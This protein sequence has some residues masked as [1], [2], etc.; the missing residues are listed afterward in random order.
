MIMKDFQKAIN[1]RYED[2]TVKNV[3]TLGVQRQFA[4]STKEPEIIHQIVTLEPEVKVWTKYDGKHNDTYVELMFNSSESDALQMYFHA[5]ETY[6]EESL[7]DDIHTMVI[8]YLSVIPFEYNGEYF[9]EAR[10]PRFWWDVPDVIGGDRS[11]L[12]IC[13]EGENVA[14]FKS[15]VGQEYLHTVLSMAIEEK[16]NNEES[17][18]EEGNMYEYEEENE[19]E[20]EDRVMALDAED[21]NRFYADIRVTGYD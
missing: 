18:E 19:Q 13:F 4:N 14:V 1:G 12:R 20:F 7:N 10:F 8:A 11:N 5:L 15:S 21:T 3:V 16:E 6:A 9:L 17:I 2:G